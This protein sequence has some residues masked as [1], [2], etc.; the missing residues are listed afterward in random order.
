VSYCHYLAVLVLLYVYL[1]TLYQHIS[2]VASN[3]VLIVNDEMRIM[4]KKEI[5]TCFE[6]YATILVEV[7]S[8]IVAGLLVPAQR[9]G[10]KSS[11]Y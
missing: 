5:M 9:S 6:D 8:K 10:H 2:F 1:T 11:E 4:W 7:L 3:D